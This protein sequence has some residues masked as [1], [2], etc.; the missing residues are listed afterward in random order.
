MNELI[1]GQA[2]RDFEVGGPGGLGE[3]QGEQGCA[4]RGRGVDRGVRGRP[5]QQP[6][7]GLECVQQGGRSGSEFGVVDLRVRKA[8]RRL[9]VEVRSG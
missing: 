4:G 3:G 7:Q 8:R 5:A 9:P 6:V 2:V 1:A